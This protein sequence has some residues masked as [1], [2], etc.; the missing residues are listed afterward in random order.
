MQILI[1]K[2]GFF[3]NFLFFLIYKLQ[4]YSITL[5]IY[6]SNENI[7]AGGCLLTGADFSGSIHFLNPKHLK[8]YRCVAKIGE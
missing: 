4:K 1:A 7:F 3:D 6:K 5:Y 8:K 2:I